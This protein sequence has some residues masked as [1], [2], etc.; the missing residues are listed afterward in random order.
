MH[1]YEITPW[2]QHISIEW[3]R[4]KEETTNWKKERNT[5]IS[6]RY[7]GVCVI[8]INETLIWNY[9]YTKSVLLLRSIVICHLPFDLHFAIFVL[10]SIHFMLNCHKNRLVLNIANVTFEKIE[11][12]Q[13]GFSKK[14]PAKVRKTA[15]KAPQCMSKNCLMW[16]DCKRFPAEKLEEEKEAKIVFY[17]R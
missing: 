9:R 5:N 13:R 7:P 14:C 3:R 10:E 15:T 17:H 2:I 8:N 11:L 6:I 1:N 12:N 16:F 4:R